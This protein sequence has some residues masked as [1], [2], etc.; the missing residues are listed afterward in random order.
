MD[1][2]AYNKTFVLFYVNACVGKILRQ[3]ILA[4]SAVAVNVVHRD[5]FSLFPL[6]KSL[7]T[8]VDRTCTETSA[9]AENTE[10]VVKAQL[11]LCFAAAD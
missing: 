7:G 9:E 11:F 8:L 4:H 6:D 10:A 3:G 1:I 5:I 2:L